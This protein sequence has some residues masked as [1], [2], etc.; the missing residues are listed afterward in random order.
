M[1]PP[2]KAFAMKKSCRNVE[3][4][5]GNPVCATFDSKLEHRYVKESMPSI[6]KIDWTEFE[7]QKTSISDEPEVGNE[8]ANAES[9]AYRVSG[10]G[11]IYGHCFRNH[12]SIMVMTQTSSP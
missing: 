8:P 3:N 7:R 12:C 10:W 11:L 1:Q 6:S 4:P 2:Y 5:V 9:F